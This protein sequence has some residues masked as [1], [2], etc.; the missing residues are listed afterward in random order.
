MSTFN[1]KSVNSLLNSATKKKIGNAVPIL[2]Y[3]GQAEKEGRVLLYKDVLTPC[4]TYEFASDDIL[5]SIEAPIN[6]LPHE[7]VILWLKN[8]AQIIYKRTLDL[9]P[10]TIVASRQIGRLGLTLRG[11]V[12]ADD[13]TSH[14]NGTCSDCTS[15][16]THSALEFSLL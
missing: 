10:N 16:C 15:H 4:D 14:C 12:A 9:T 3:M 7:G 13:C 6:V 2:G 8:D 1:T 11:S 5:H